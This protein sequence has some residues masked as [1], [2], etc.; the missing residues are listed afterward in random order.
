MEKSNGNKKKY[1]ENKPKCILAEDVNTFY[2]LNF[3][4]AQ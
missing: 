4:N 2:Q 3:L 1:W